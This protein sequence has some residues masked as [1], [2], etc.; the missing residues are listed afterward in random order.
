VRE[1]NPNQ[2]G[3]LEYALP[4]LASVLVGVLI[5]VVSHYIL[6]FPPFST[7]TIC[8]LLILFVWVIYLNTQMR[9]LRSDLNRA[10]D[11]TQGMGEIIS[12]FIKSLGNTFDRL[13]QLPEKE[14]ITKESLL[15]IFGQPFRNFFGDTSDALLKTILK[16]SPERHEEIRRLMEKANRREISY[17]EA[18]RLRELLEEEKKKREEIG[19]ILGVIALGLLLLFILGLLASLLLEKRR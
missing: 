13:L 5:A 3:I 8:I 16:S 9:V 12:I 10:T 6:K 17:E 7:A 4:L 2:H 14:K 18:E 1:K 15:N 11:S 19:D